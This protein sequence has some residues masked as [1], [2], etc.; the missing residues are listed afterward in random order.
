MTAKRKT[1]NEPGEASPQFVKV[2]ECLYR[3]QP[4][5]VYYALVKHAGKQHRKSLKTTDRKLAERKLADFRRK[6][7]G[8]ARQKDAGGITFDALAKRWLESMKPS[9]KA[10]SFLRRE[11][12]V[13]QLRPHIGELTIK[14]LSA[15]VF[16]DW[17]AKR[18]PDI[19]ASTYNNERETIIGVLNYAH[20]EGL[21]LDNPALVL[22]RRKLPKAA[23]V[24]PTKEQFGKLVATLRA[25]GTR[26]ADAADLV[27][28]LAYSGT[29]LGEA[30]AMRW[31]DVSF[32]RER[33]AVTGGEEGTKN[34]EARDVPLFPALRTFLQRIHERDEP[35]DNDLIVRIGTATKAIKK[36]CEK[37]ELP[38]F[39]HH[40]LRHYFVSNAIE[41]GVDFKTIAAWVGHKDG[42]LLVAKTYGHLRDTHS[43]EMAKRMTFAA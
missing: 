12:S 11:N 9:L 38:A 26:F 40:S 6:V 1:S 41:A 25:L 36:A 35:G 4:S 15:T 17:A 29:R 20:R 37:G 14:Q 43:A 39:T 19:A 33:F 5:K 23:L 22:K 3:Y 8:L 18:S 42:G 16:E 10:K 21:L 27:E 2:A 24:I 28:L 7:S 13:N 31:R 30:T 32:D 34:H